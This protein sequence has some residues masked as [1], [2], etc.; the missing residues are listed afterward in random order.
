MDGAQLHVIAVTDRGAILAVS[1]EEHLD[2]TR[3]KRGD[4]LPAVGGEA[5]AVATA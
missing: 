1:E 2:T 3:A 5:V 4:G